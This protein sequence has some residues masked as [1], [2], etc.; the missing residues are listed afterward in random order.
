MQRTVFLVAGAAEKALMRQAAQMVQAQSQNCVTFVEVAASDSRFKVKVTAYNASTTVEDRFCFAYP[1]KV[2]AFAARNEQPTIF[3]HGQYGCLG[4]PDSLTMLMKFWTILTGTIL[5]YQLV[6]LMLQ[7]RLPFRASKRAPTRRSRS[8][9]HGQPKRPGIPCRKT[10][11][12]L[13]PSKNQFMLF[14]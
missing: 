14:V 2:T 6:V 1:G 13:R 9:H 4:M 12:I 10:T 5:T 11:F 7:N 8:I 3:T